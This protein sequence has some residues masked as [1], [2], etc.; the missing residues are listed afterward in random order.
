MTF[1]C[2]APNAFRSLHTPAFPAPALLSAT[3]TSCWREISSG[4]VG[5]LIVSEGLFSAFLEGMASAHQR[6]ELLWQQ[7][8]DRLEEGG[9][10]AQQRSKHVKDHGLA[11][12]AVVGGNG[13]GETRG[14]VLENLLTGTGVGAG[15]GSLATEGHRAGFTECGT[16][17]GPVCGCRREPWTHSPMSPHCTGPCTLWSLSRGLQM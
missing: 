1:R 4:R 2:P 13:C 16:C 8:A 3:E 5:E 9:R 11:S 14:S 7:H 10:W 6:T 17:Q 15:G 12:E